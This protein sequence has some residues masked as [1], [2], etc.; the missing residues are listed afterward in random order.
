[1]VL[2]VK[3]QPRWSSPYA[4]SA[5]IPHTHQGMD[6]FGLGLGLGQ[7][8]DPDIET[9]PPVRSHFYRL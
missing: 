3:L 6:A 9:V 8:L 4:V 1:M 7:C 2:P 5:P